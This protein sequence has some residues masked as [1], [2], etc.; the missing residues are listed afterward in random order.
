MSKKMDETREDALGEQ[1]M[2][3]ESEEK[4][5]KFVSLGAKLKKLREAQGISISD[6]AN[7]TKIQQ[8]FIASMEKGKLDSLPKGPYLRG[9]LRQYC[10]YL[11]ADDLWKTY[12]VLT[13][14]Q[15]VQFVTSSAKEEQVGYSAKPR[16]FKP[17]PVAFIYIIV[18]LSL[19]A[20]GLITWQFR[21]SMSFAPIGQEKIF[22]VQSEDIQTSAI[23]ADNSVR[24]G[25]A[26]VDLGWMD[27]NPLSSTLATASADSE[28]NSPLSLTK[29][30]EL[31]II[32]T[33][34]VWIRVSQSNETLFQGL[35]KPGEEKT[36]TV[37]EKAP[38]G[39]KS[40]KPGKTSLVWQGKNIESMGDNK[41]PIVRFYWFD[42]RVTETDQN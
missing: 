8:H 36:F 35:I 30:P 22:S 26:A 20:A 2:L 33:A 4:N 3:N 21:S 25:D 34:I 6:V 32:P 41:V 14:D 10:A 29:E 12:D 9:F 40:G 28:P 17:T 23:S 1:Q 18:I 31:K 7:H 39:L 24:S 16:I 37:T 13:K 5:S 27:G 19:L 42:G 15:K 38:L 11:S